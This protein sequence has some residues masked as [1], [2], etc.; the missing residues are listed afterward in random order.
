MKKIAL[1]AL[2]LALASACQDNEEARRNLIGRWSYD[3]EGILNSARMQNPTEN[4]M[5]IVQGAMS[6]YKDAVFEFGEDGTLIVITNGIEQRGTWELADDGSQLYINL[7]GQGQ[8]NDILELSEKRLV[9][10][11]IPESGLFYRRIFIP[12]PR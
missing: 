9:L 2:L 6:I 3:V 11:P 12:A 1:F 7:S 4:E 5:A 10:A 8:P